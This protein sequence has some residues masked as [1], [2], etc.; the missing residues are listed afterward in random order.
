M[1]KEDSGSRL[2][3]IDAFNLDRLNTINNFE[4]GNTATIGFDY[5]LKKTMLI[6]LIF[7]SLKLSMKRKTKNFIPKLV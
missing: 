4:T 1:R 5:N 6:N 2:T 3:P 7:L